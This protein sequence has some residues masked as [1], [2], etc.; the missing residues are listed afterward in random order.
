MQANTKYYADQ[1]TETNWTF[2]SDYN[3]G[4]TV[5]VIRTAALLTIARKLGNIEN[6]IRSLGND[7]IHDLIRTELKEVKRKIRNRKSKGRK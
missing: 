4:F 1:I 6:Q 2:T 3:G 7:G 5:D